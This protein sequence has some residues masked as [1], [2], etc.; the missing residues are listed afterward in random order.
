MFHLAL[1]LPID[2]ENSLLSFLK[3]YSI[4]K[5][6][7]FLRFFYIHLF[8][9]PSSL[10]T[11]LPRRERI[12]GWVCIII[13]GVSGI[14]L[15]TFRIKSPG[16]IWETTFGIVWFIK[17]SIYLIMVL[18]AAIATTRINR[19]LRKS[20]EQGSQSDLPLFNGTDGNL[21]SHISALEKKEF[22]TVFKKFIGKKPNTTYSITRAGKKAFT[23]HLDAL[24]K[25]I[26][27][28]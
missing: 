15:T 18:I 19:M 23:E 2:V 22:I 5:L 9:K 24:E 26:K 12:L 25:L 27:S 20:H 6:D 11:G 7:I 3:S 17:V 14:I 16:E 1:I 4:G 13:V 28:E 10:S 21:A 8:V